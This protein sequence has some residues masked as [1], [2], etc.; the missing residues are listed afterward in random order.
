[1]ADY[2]QYKYCRMLEYIESM[3]S[4]QKVDNHIDYILSMRSATSIERIIKTYNNTYQFLARLSYGKKRVPID[5]YKPKNWGENKE[6]LVEELNELLN[7]SILSWFNRQEHITNEQA[8][9][10]ISN[11]RSDNNTKLIEDEILTKTKPKA[12]KGINYLIDIRN[13]NNNIRKYIEDSKSDAYFSEKLYI[14]NCK[15][16]AA[17]KHIF[18]IAE[19]AFGKQYGISYYNLIEEYKI[20]VAEE[21]NRIKQKKEEEIMQSMK[22]FNKV[23]DK[24]CGVVF[25]AILG[26][27]FAL[28][29]GIIGSMGKKR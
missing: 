15:Y 7:E 18:D 2:S 23:L 22:G 25:S 10:C 14:S 6:Y 29:G 11:L 17:H 16:L 12:D 24:T 19:I 4:Q 5:W 9:M 27:P 3:S 1:M 28:F 21:E 13:K 20:E 8:L 26:L